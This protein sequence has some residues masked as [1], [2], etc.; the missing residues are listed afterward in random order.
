[1]NEHG[2]LEKSTDEG[3]PHY[4]EKNL[5]QCHFIPSNPTRT[6]EEVLVSYYVLVEI[7]LRNTLLMA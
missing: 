4:L 1:M 5:S 2:A 6:V 7:I 3:R